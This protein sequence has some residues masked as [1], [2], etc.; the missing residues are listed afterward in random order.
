MVAADHSRYARQTMLPQIGADGQRRIAA[1]SVLIVGLGGL[2]APVAS[3]LAGA[4]VGRLGLCDADTVSLSN[5]QRQILYAEAQLDMPKT[6]AAQARLS[7]ISSATVFDLHAGG[8][9]DDN[10]ACI[11]ACYDLVVDCCDNFATRYLI[12]DTC[13]ALGKPW[14]YGSIGEFAGQLAVM[15]GRAG[16]RYSALYPDRAALCG[17]PRTVAGVLGPVPG[18]IGAMQAAEALKWLAGIESPLDGSVFAID[19]LTLQTFT[20]KF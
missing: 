3:Y 9:T 16:G 18:V 13:H 1:A 19:L 4:G 10:A 8:L 11:I 2:G 7:A 17:R 12:D 15:G 5:L 6:D 14:I 20:M